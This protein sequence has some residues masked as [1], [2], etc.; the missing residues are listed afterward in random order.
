[1]AKKKQKGG[2]IPMFSKEQLESIGIEKKSFFKRLICKHEF[3]S[4]SCHHPGVLS[5]EDIYHICTK[6]GKSKHLI[7]AEFEGWG[8]K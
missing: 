6:C 1:M 7:F 2:G 3:K 4:F 5:G 8:Y